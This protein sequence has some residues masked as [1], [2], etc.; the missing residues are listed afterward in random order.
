MPAYIIF[1]FD[2]TLADTNK[3]IVETFKRTMEI[4]GIPSPSDEEITATI[5]LPLKQ[6]FLVAVKGISDE[7]ADECVRTYRS[8]FDDTALPKIQAF[9]EVKET[10]KAL[11]DRGI[12]MVIATSRGHRSLKIICNSLGISGYFCGSYCAED[13]QHHKPDPEIVNLILKEHN[14][15]PD[16][17]IVVGDTTFDLM[18]GQAA[19]CRVCGVT[20]GNHSEETLRSVNP[21]WIIHSMAELTDYRE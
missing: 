21:D 15:T 5:G 12:R 20:W 4:L 9:P 11:Y 17:A 10:L 1:D 16:D 6:N 13:V 8:I 3:G 19:G 18:M 7:T 14:I 2:G